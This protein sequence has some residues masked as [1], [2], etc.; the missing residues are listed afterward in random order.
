MEHASENASAPSEPT[1]VA[2][3]ASG[4]NGQNGDKK[5][6]FDDRDRPRRGRGGGALKHGSSGRG[7]P[8][9]K[10]NMGRNEHLYVVAVAGSA[11]L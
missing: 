5:R 9:K 4:D 3:N 7:N 11:L 1:T 10:R 8:N 2:D 6:K